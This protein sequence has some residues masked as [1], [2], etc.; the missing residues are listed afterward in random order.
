MYCRVY[1]TYVRVE[2][3]AINIKPDVHHSE[4]RDA[5][6]DGAAFNLKIPHK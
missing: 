4:R 3:N 2:H 6:T 5:N 1:N